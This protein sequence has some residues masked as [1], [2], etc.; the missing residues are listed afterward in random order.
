MHP[1][2]NR[3]PLVLA[4]VVVPVD[5]P[6]Q[7]PDN[8]KEDRDSADDANIVKKSNWPKLVHLQTCPTCS[9]SF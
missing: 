9:N 6:N 1:A 3:D 4:I 5:Q 7:Q 8:P 2:S